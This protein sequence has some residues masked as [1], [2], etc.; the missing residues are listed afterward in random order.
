MSKIIID[1]YGDKRWLFNGK[2]HR[3]DGPAVEW[4]NGDREWW[5]NGKRHRDGGPAV[6]CVDGNR[7][8]YK[9]G[10]C[11][12]EDGPAVELSDET[13]LWY[14]NGELLTREAWFEMIPEESKVKALFCEHFIKR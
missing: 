14:L 2:L 4:V 1:E 11:H 9:A 13:R 8:W 7:H 10:K 5:F 3:E 12:R 6:E